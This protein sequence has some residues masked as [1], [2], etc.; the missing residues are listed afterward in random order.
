MLPPAAN[1]GSSYPTSSTSICCHIFSLM[2]SPLTGV[3]GDF[4]VF[5]IFISLMAQYVDYIFLV[6]VAISF[7]FFIW[8]LS[9]HFVGSFPDWSF[10]LL[11][12]NFFHPFTNHP[13][14]HHQ[15]QHWFHCIWFLKERQQ[16][17]SLHRHTKCEKWRPR[18]KSQDVSWIIIY[19][20]IRKEVPGDFHL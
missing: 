4:K 13:A 2:L 9:I 17:F 16:L 19:P 12:L 20:L 18:W 15:M 11:G 10:F 8:E 1:K 5:S 14:A 3:G 6:F 7:F